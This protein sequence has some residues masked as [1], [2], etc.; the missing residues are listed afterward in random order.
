MGVPRI[1]G[2]GTA[3]PKYA[4][5]QGEIEKFVAALF[6]EHVDHLDRLL[7]VFE[8]SCIDT[9]HLSKPLDWYSTAHSFAQ[10]NAI[11]EQVA[12][13]LTEEAALQAMKMGKVEAKDIGMVLRYWGIK[14]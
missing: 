4:L 3:V 2:I 12:L 11:F 10:A 13:D 8:S 6:Q 7:P 14:S 9:R 1:Q 5:K